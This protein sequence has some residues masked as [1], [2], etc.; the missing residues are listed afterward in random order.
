MT[1]NYKKNEKFE[2]LRIILS[3]DLAIYKPNEQVT[4]HV[5]MKVIE[6]LK[7]NSISINLNG[8]ADVYWF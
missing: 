3:K 7:I 1:K 8:C 6:K 5:V 4:G 2:Y